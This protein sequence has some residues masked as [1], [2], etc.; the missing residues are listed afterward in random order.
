MLGHNSFN[1]SGATANAKFYKTVTGWPSGFQRFG[2]TE[3]Y[4][5]CPSYDLGLQLAITTSYIGEDQLDYISDHSLHRNV[6]Q[7][8][9]EF[10]SPAIPFSPFTAYPYM[11]LSVRRAISPKFLSS[12]LLSPKLLFSTGL[13]SL[14]A[15][16]VWMGHSSA[17][18]PTHQDN[19]KAV[20]EEA[21]QIVNREYVDPTF[22]RNDWQAVRQSL[23]KPDYKSNKEAYDALRSA[24]KKLDDPYTRFMDRQQYEA[25]NNQTA[26]ELSGVGIRLEAKE[27]TKQLTVVEPLP[28]SPAI[29]AGVRS[30]DELV[31]INGQST[32]GMSVEDA[33]AKIRGEVGS[34]VT[35]RIRRAEEGE[36][37]LPLTR[38]RIELVTVRYSLRNEGGKPIG[39]IR[40]N[41]FSSHASDQMR[42]A[43]QDLIKQNAEAFVLDLRGNPGGL[44]QASIEISRMWLEKGG[45]VKTVDRQGSSEEVS[46][47][48]SSLTQKPMVVLVDGNS[49]SSS[50]ILTG[51]LK[52]NKRATIVGTQTFGKALVQSVYPLSDKSGLAVTIAHYYTP[53]GTDISQKGITPD[54]IVQLTEA[55]GKTLSKNPKLIATLEDPQYARA[56]ELILGTAN[57]AGSAQ[58]KASQQATPKPLQ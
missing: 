44:L 57:L 20:I 18:P 11:K 25:L 46:A 2:Y 19:P 37:D 32:K 7:L 50:E 8:C 3:A 40:L 38:A 33:S 30:G 52:D 35:L 49:A 10:V 51:A 43:L 6:Y 58:Q 1:P 41:E 4:Y 14:A 36:F 34:K 21:W 29:K 55:Q 54:V 5:V 53:N 45:I 22:N 31:A 15:M 48:R 39:Y 47:N 23:L 26:G 24:L 17:I 13:V 16:M 28:N 9:L 12:K 27:T 56:V 42:S